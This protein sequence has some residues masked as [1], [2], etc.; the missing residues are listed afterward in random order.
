LEY[1]PKLNRWDDRDENNHNTNVDRP[2][3]FRNTHDFSQRIIP[4]EPKRRRGWDW[5]GVIIIGPR[6]SSLRVLSFAWFVLLTFLL[7]ACHSTPSDEVA[8]AIV[9]WHKAVQLGDGQKAC[10]LMS[11]SAQDE[12]ASLAR[13]ENCRSAIG[14]I[15]Q[16]FSSD[17][18]NAFMNV[19]VAKDKIKAEGTQAVVPAGA[20]TYP[21]SGN[22]ALKFHDDVDLTQIGGQWKITSVVEMDP[23]H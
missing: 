14:L 9:S 4:S 23:D 21:S 16:G 19:N 5:R 17:D 7:T 13:V 8:A 1:D 10:D 22:D 6:F 12:L 18:K 15:A 20:I 3:T 2:V 11:S